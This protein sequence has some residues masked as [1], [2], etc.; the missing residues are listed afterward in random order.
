MESI[1]AVLCCAATAMH[2]TFLVKF[3]AALLRF[4]INGRR[5]ALKLSVALL[6]TTVNR[7]VDM[8]RVHT[9]DGYILFCY[10]SLE[11]RRDAGS[12]GR[13]VAEDG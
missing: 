10:L 1:S 11:G 12:G 9:G 2:V 13:I 5:R 6:S 7:L 3:E 4:V 8:V